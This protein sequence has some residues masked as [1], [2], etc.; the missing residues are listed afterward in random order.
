MAALPRVIKKVYFR[1]AVLVLIGGEE[2]PL[3]QAATTLYA[4]FGQRKAEKK[5]KF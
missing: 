1:G 5:K 4:I 3:R 2:P